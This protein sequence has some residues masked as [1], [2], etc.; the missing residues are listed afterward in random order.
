VIHQTEHYILKLIKTRQ[1]KKIIEVLL[2]SDD[3]YFK[4]SETYYIVGECYRLLGKY[5]RARLFLEVACQLDGKSRH[6]V[7]ALARIYHLLARYEEAYAIL[8]GMLKRF[9][10]DGHIRLRIGLILSQQGNSN[11]AMNCF[12]K[13]RLRL[14]NNRVILAEEKY[15][16]EQPFEDTSDESLFATVLYNAIGVVLLHLGEEAEAIESFCK[17]ISSKPLG[18]PFFDPYINLDRL[19]RSCCSGEVK[20]VINLARVS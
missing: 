14:E 8:T 15:G 12:H 9:S 10:A 2:T 16:I 5:D 19:E 13:L 11:A 4:K 1:Y 7:Y 18:K 20:P 3:K 6:I 17:A